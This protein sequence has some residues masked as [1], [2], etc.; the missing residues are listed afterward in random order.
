[1]KTTGTIIAIVIGIITSLNVSAK[2]TND[3]IFNHGKKTGTV[4][5]LELDSLKTIGMEEESPVMDIFFLSDSSN[6]NQSKLQL[7][8]YGQHLSETREEMGSEIL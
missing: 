1:M 5:Y 3:S 7:A 4:T 8:I 6:R 2:G